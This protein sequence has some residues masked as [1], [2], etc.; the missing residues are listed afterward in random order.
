MILKN[1]VSGCMGVC[2][3]NQ[4]FFRTLECCPVPWS[5]IGQCSKQPVF[6]MKVTRYI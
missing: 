5:E 1:A 3:E 6:V 2:F 4:I